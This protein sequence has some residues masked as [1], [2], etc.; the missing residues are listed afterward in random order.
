MKNDH[1]IDFFFFL[2]Q[3][4]LHSSKFHTSFFLPAREP[5]GFSIWTGPPFSNGQPSV[6]LERI[7]CTSTRFSENGSRLMVMKSNSTISIYDCRSF[8]EIRAFEIPSV[9]AATL[10]P[11]GTYLQTFQKASTPQEKNL[12]LWEAVTGNP[13]YYQFQKNMSKTTWFVTSFQKIPF[14]FFFTFSSWTH[15]DLICVM[16]IIQLRVHL[17]LYLSG[18]L[19]YFGV[20]HH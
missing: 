2:C 12:V 8:T 9:L 3:T 7:P 17:V 20:I 16:E 14:F 11:C 5:E 13:V 15:P 4:L 1:T 10:S 18:T 19:H 6:K